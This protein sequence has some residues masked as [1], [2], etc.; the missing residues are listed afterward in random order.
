MLELK[1]LVS[2]SVSLPDENKLCACYPFKI[3]IVQYYM[4][5]NS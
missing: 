2:W 1:Q 5:N 3:D 4:Y